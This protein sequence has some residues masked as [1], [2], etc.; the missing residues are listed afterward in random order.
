MKKSGLMFVLWLLS[1]AGGTAQVTLQLSLEQ[2]QFLPGEILPLAVRI[3]NRSGQTINLGGDN[4][5]L[6]F[7]V[8]S[9]DVPVVV[10]TGEPPVAEDIVLDS[11]HAAIKE[12]NIAPYFN[13]KKPGHYTVSATAML[14]DWNR[15]ISSAPISFDIVNAAS[16]REIEFGVPLP[17]GVSNRPPEVRKYVLLQAN[18]LKKLMLYFQLSE[19]T[20][21][22]DK[23]YTL[24]QMLNMNLQDTQLDRLSNL[25][26]LYQ[27]GAHTS[28]Y[29]MIN[30][31]GE[32]MKRQ[33]YEFTTRPRLR[34]EDDGRVVVVAA[35]RVE[36]P[37]DLPVSLPEKAEPVRP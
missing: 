22:H 11:A 2:E 35:A 25:H 4:D 37:N 10:R 29:V 5:W 28:S 8:E 6:K 33:T 27:V 31:D 16:L 18:Y 12:V 7:T 20:G 24:G 32:L 36:R 13:L 1:L 19:P 23:V 15:Q 17:A 14:K 26:V 3:V 30:P 34:I 9:R 21:K